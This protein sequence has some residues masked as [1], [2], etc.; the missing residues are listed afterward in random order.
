MYLRDRS[1]IEAWGRGMGVGILGGF[2]RAARRGRVD[3][4]D[5]QADRIGGALRDCEL[6][7]AG[8]W[9]CG[10]C[11][12]RGCCPSRS[13]RA[14]TASRME[15]RSR[16]VVRARH[17][18]SFEYQV[19]SIARGLAVGHGRPTHIRARDLRWRHCRFTPFDAAK[20]HRPVY[21]QVTS[22][23][24]TRV[25]QRPKRSAPL[26]RAI[27][28]VGRICRPRQTA[29]L[30][31]VE[32]PVRRRSPPTRRPCAGSCSAG[33]TGKLTVVRW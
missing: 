8:A 2:Q 17:P 10:S 32:R 18:W 30:R 13:P 4:G 23:A 5:G 6:R 25:R 9:E 29:A 33:V 22:Q 24:L 16:R 31:A 14:S 11:R 19:T 12:A 1:G 27:R 26:A 3:D 21:G 15:A 20:S 28:G 7:I